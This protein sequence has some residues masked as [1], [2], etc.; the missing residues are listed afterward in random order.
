MD[1]LAGKIMSVIDAAWCVSLMTACRPTIMT[2]N[3]VFPEVIPEIRHSEWF[4]LNKICLEVVILEM[5]DQI[6]I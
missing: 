1:I 3:H 5:T 6:E 4:L 2:V